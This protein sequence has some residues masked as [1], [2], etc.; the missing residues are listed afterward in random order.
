[1][2]K[3]KR[4]RWAGHVTLVGEMR[5]AHRILVG[6]SGEKRLLGRPRCGWEVNIKMGFKGS[7]V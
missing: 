2:I 4:M 6:K 5:N 1:M 7:R 3:S